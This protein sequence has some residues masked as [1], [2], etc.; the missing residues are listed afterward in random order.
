MYAKLKQ[1][2]PEDQSCLDTNGHAKPGATF[3]LLW[4]KGGI[5]HVDRAPL[6][7]LFINHFIVHP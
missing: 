5:R 4:S 7:Q 2:W 3:G 6:K 1:Q